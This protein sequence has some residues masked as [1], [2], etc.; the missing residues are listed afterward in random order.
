MDAPPG[1]D[2]EL[3]QG[4]NP[5]SGHIL[6]VHLGHGAN[7]SS[8]GSVVDV[9]FASAVAGSAVLASMAI[10]LERRAEA[11]KGEGNRDS[12]ENEAPATKADDGEES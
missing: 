10:L 1:K 7:C 2:R 8:V 6:S 4:N 5:V 9:L 11:R 12:R 3:S